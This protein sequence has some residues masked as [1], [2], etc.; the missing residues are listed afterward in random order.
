MI[1]TDLS[2]AT[3][4]GTAPGFGGPGVA[5]SASD[6]AQAE[7]VASTSARFQRQSHKCLLIS[8][9]ELYALTLPT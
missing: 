6:P 1:A 4:F 3:P 9:L 7:P 2:R 8:D 5:A